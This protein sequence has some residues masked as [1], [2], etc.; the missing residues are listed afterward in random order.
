MI[1]KYN[2]QASRNG[3][4][5][6]SMGGFDSV[7]ADVG[8]YMA[9]EWLRRERHT[10]TRHLQ[11]YMRMSGGGV[12]GGTVASVMQMLDSPITADDSI[13]SA[14]LLNPPAFHYDKT[15][16]EEKDQLLPVYDRTVGNWT[17]RNH[18]HMLS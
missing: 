7:P 17:G 13:I 14:Y 10:A 1:S 16:K 12:S 9:A 2:G 11:G 4:L 5:L 15:R 6:I 8:A 3:A 18:M